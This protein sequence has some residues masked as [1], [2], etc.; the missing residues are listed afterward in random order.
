MTPKPSVV[1]FAR[2]VIQL[3][4][5]YGE[6]AALSAVH[7]D[8]DH[9]VLEEERFQVVIHGLPRGV[10]ASIRVTAPPVV[11][12]NNPIKLCLPVASIEAARQKASDLGGWVGP[13]AKEWEARGF[14]ACDG[15]D[16]EGNVFQLRESVPTDAIQ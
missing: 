15:Y 4:R 12:K 14:R 9:V 13:R 11:R 1:V 8:A 7:S 6:V 3:A 2:D 10:A 16:P 5:F